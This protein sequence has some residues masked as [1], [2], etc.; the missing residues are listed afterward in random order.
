M[1]KAGYVSQ[2]K[3]FPDIEGNIIVQYGGGN[4]MNPGSYDRYT[5]FRNNPEADF[6]VIAW[7]LGLL[8]ASCNPFKKKRQLKG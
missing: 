6:L 2:M 7:P 4:M 1:N 3:S 8:Q 5:P